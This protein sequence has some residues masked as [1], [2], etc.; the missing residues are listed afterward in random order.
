MTFSLGEEASSR[1]WNPVDIDLVDLALVTR[2]QPF[3]HTEDNPLAPV[4]EHQHL[5][6]RVVEVDTLDL[7]RPPELGESLLVGHVGGRHPCRR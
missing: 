4:G 6:R 2:V 3:R 5:S 7:S 1:I